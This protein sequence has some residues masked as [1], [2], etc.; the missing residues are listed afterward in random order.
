[1]NS[2]MYSCAQMSGS[3]TPA[4]SSSMSMG[5]PILTASSIVTLCFEYV[6]LCSQRSANLLPRPLG[7]DT[8]RSF[9]FPD[10]GFVIEG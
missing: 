9:F 6:S 5:S 1:M 4:F 3:S 2:H 7:V 10:R 8:I